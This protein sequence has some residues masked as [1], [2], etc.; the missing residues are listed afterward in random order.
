MMGENLNNL[1]HAVRDYADH[2][3]TCSP[4]TALPIDKHNEWYRRCAFAIYRQICL[5]KNRDRRLAFL[6]ELF[7]RT[8]NSTYEL[9]VS[10]FRA[11][12]RACSIYLSELNEMVASLEQ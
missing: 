11:L 4:Q 1:I 10:E 8:I 2:M 9:R 6:S 7:G 3:E 12:Q 5:D